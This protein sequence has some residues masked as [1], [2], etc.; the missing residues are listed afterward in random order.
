MLDVSALSPTACDTI[1]GDWRLTQTVPPT[2][3]GASEVVINTTQDAAS[4]T[5][6]VTFTWLPIAYTEDGGWYQVLTRDTVANVVSLR[7]TTET[8][9]GKTA[10]ELTVTIPG[11]PTKFAYFVRTFTPAHEGNQNDLTS[12]DSEEA[13][14]DANAISIVELKAGAPLLYLPALAP[15]LLLVLTGAAVVLVSRK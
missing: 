1:F 12:V 10:A 8:T 13:L 11:D 2:S 5:A 4:V 9:G 14:I 15:L 6:D 7:G 3:I